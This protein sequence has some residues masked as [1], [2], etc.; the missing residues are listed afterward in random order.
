MA[1]ALAK[2]ASKDGTLRTKYEKGGA[3]HQRIKQVL[4]SKCNRPDCHMQGCLPGRLNEQR[5]HDFLDSYWSLTDE[6]RGHL[7]RVT[8]AGDAA[9]QKCIWHLVGQRVCFHRFCQVVG[10]SGPTIRKLLAGTPD[11]RKA[12]LAPGLVL[13][14]PKPA[15][16]EAKCHAWFR[17]LHQ[18]TAAPDPGLEL[19]TPMYSRTQ[20]ASGAQKRKRAGASLIQ[21][22]WAGWSYNWQVA[23][24]LTTACLSH[25]VGLPVRYLVRLVQF[26]FG[27]HG[28]R[29]RHT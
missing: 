14:L 10:S 4:H 23:P 7:L 24:P 2:Q 16:Q 26:L 28:Y 8:A 15:L 18:T 12:M 29:S 3:D 19:G 20:G 13:A 22:P 9:D 27:C 17:Q 1:A 21:D 25:V 5:I 6:E 11:T